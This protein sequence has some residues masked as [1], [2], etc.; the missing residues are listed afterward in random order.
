MS[1]RYAVVEDAKRITEIKV[2][3]WKTAYRGIFPDEFL[4]TLDAESRIESV[5]EAIS[6]NPNNGFV[7]EDEDKN[8]LGFCQFGG[9]RW[10]EEF[11]EE[12]DCE[13][14]AIYVLSE[15]RGQ[16]I[17]SALF[18]ATLAEF[19]SRNKKGMLVNV[20]EENTASVNFYKKLGGYEVGKKDFILKEVAYW[21][22]VFAFKL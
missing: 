5:K 3:G 19:K 14:Y 18:N 7:F 22:I 10:V 13:L 9:S 4:E 12:Y 8:I 15:S 16:G 6:E 11:G 2:D 20:L 21:Q 1:V 17:G